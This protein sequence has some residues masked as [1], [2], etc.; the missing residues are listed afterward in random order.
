MLGLPRCMQA[1]SSCSELGLFFM[2]CVDFSLIVEMP[3]NLSKESRVIR[4]QL[5][6]GL[7]MFIYQKIDKIILFFL[8]YFCCTT[9]LAG[10]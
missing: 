7:W 10:Y 8:L 4:F 5:I 6:Y 3:L 1:F 9:Q 2:W